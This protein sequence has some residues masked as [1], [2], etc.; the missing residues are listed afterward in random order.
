MRLSKIALCG[1][2]MAGLTLSSGCSSVLMPTNMPE[3]TLIHFNGDSTVNGSSGFDPTFTTSV[4]EDTSDSFLGMREMPEEYE[5]EESDQPG[6]TLE[7]E[8]E[9]PLYDFGDEDNATFIDPKPTGQTET[10]TAM[11]YLPYGYDESQQYDIIYLMHGMSGTQYTFLGNG[12]E[13]Q[14]VG[15]KYVLD[16]MIAHGDIKP[17]IVVCP[18]I[19][20]GY[21]NDSDI[22]EGVAID[23]CETLMPIVE[24]KYSTYA[25]TPDAAGFEA[26]RKHRCMAGF[27]M[28]GCDTWRVM[29]RYPQ[30]FYYYN[31]NSMIIDANL[32]AKIDEPTSNFIEALQAKGVTKDSMEVYYGIGTDDYT[33]IFVGRQYNALRVHDDIFDTIGADETWE[34]GNLMYR[35][36]PGRFHRYYEAYPY[37][38]NAFTMF[39]RTDGEPRHMAREEGPHGGHGHHHEEGGPHGHRDEHMGPPQD[40]V[41]PNFDGDQGQDAMDPEKDFDHH[42]GHHE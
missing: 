32:K 31:P 30:Y 13:G 23:I 15:F 26:S 17:V 1:S 10:K 35:M 20:A 34:D 38:Y 33:N 9:S 42:H 22:T 2:L 12:D 19:S 41:D 25:E 7:L 37:F 16:N 4:M 3:E 24:S 39:F 5:T 6:T 40:R 11:I 18:T 28:G 27:S 8:Y 29:W 21:D 14:E 36:W